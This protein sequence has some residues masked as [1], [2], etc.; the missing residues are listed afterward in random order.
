MN[1]L[2]A[3]FTKDDDGSMHNTFGD[4]LTFQTEYLEE[5]WIT[6]DSDTK[7][8]HPA[9]PPTFSETKIKNH[10]AQL[11]LLLTYLMMTNVLDDASNDVQM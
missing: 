2:I 9:K 10:G 3:D 8:K 6:L 5:G 1:Q 7:V 11:L 4:M